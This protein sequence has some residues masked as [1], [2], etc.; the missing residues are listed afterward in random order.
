MWLPSFVL[1]A[2]GEFP[3]AW[4]VSHGTERAH[5][6]GDCGGSWAGWWPLSGGVWPWREVVSPG[7]GDDIGSP[8]SNT[9]L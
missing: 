7:G 6:T 1:D 4:R 9:L 5:V 3:S 2:S 8:S